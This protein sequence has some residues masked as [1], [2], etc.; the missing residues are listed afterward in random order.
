MK[1]GQIGKLVV[2]EGFLVGAIGVVGGVVLGLALGHVL[3]RHI[4]LAQTGWYLPYRPSW[5]SVVETALLVGAG[6]ALAGWYPARH[7]ARLVIADALE[8][9]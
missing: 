4:N 6:S 7:A 5:S 1:R 3:L 9:E 8:Y 2:I